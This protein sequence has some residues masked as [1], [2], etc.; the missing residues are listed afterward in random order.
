MRDQSAATSEAA[1][2]SIRET[3]PEPPDRARPAAP[4]PS[5]RWPMH[6]LLVYPEFPE[7]FWSFKHALKF[8]G[9]QA[10]QPPLGLMTVAA[11]LPRWWSKRLVDT[12]VERL[13]D[14]DLAWAAVV[15]LSGMPIPSDS[16]LVESGVSVAGLMTQVLPETSA[17][18]NF[19]LGMAMGKFHGVIRP[20]TPIG[21]RR[22][23]ANLFLNSL[24]VV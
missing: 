7:T 16:L 11:L 6:A 8:L 23:I 4:P 21:T 17:G 18:N 14:R 2:G 13:R 24:G 12:N 1:A 5:Y 10:A 20:T 19:Q 3:R 9:K 15:L 22:L